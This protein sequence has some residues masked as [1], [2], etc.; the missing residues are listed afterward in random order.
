MSR[1][2]A[3]PSAIARRAGQIMER[4]GEDRGSLPA[5]G[6]IGGCHGANVAGTRWRG[7]T[8]P[9]ARGWQLAFDADVRGNG[10][11]L[12]DRRVPDRRHMAIE[13][14]DIEIRRERAGE[15]AGVDLTRSIGQFFRST[16]LHCCHREPRN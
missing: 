13:A 11:K 10:P 1:F 16:G 14:A 9:L 7:E 5:S 15:G 8:E 2:A 6:C 12:D 3:I 4:A